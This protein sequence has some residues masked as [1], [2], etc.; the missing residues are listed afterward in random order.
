MDLFIYLHIDGLVQKCNNS[1]AL[2][3][4]KSCALPSTLL[5]KTN[6]LMLGFF[7][8]QNSLNVDVL[9]HCHFQ[10]VS[11]E[12]ISSKTCCLSYAFLTFA[13]ATM[14]KGVVPAAQALLSRRHLCA[15]PTWTP[16]W[17]NKD[18]ILSDLTEMHW[19]HCLKYK[20]ICSLFDLKVCLKTY[21]NGHT[22]Q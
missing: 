10:D 21:P 12:T 5:T 4:L 17:E 15:L 8:P 3:L 2:E 13:K 9:V 22:A 11:V 19:V 7:I 16:M 1:I 6:L 20:I 18:S 14:H